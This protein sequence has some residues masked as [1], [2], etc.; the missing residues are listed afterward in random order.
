MAVQS[1]SVFMLLLGSERRVF[2]ESRVFAECWIFG[3]TFSER[4]PARDE[5]Y[6]AGDEENTGPSPGTDS[7]MQKN[8]GQERGD[9]VT[10]GRCRQ[11]ECEISPGERGEV[12]VEKSGEK[13]NAEND[14]R[15]NEGVEDVG[16]VVEVVFAEVVQA[17]FEQHVAR[18][19]AAGDGQIDEDFLELHSDVSAINPRGSRG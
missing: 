9:D 6:A 10:E 14:P 12:R 19:V 2:A 17:A 13:K 18:A 11:N 4:R 16:P 8:T 15:I 1:L 5:A 7:L 3:M